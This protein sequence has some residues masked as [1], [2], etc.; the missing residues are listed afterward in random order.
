M[1]RLLL[2]SLLWLVGCAG[3][4]P[5][6]VTVTL[7]PPPTLAHAHAWLTKEYPETHCTAYLNVDAD[8]Q[9][10]TWLIYTWEVPSG[11][12]LMACPTYNSWGG[13]RTANMAN[14]SF[15][16]VGSEAGSW[17]REHRRLIDTRTASR[18]TRAN[19]GPG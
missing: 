2:I 13:P 7:T 6:M 8:A 3:P 9:P 19:A 14:A 11:G 1:K 15:T 17:S 5:Q 4:R 16:S 12:S 10:V 18:Y